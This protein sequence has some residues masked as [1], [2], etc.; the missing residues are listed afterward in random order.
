MGKITIIS[1]SGMGRSGRK[2]RGVVPSAKG[3]KLSGDAVVVKMIT[4][5]DED[6]FKSVKVPNVVSGIKRELYKGPW[7]N[8]RIESSI[9]S[10]MSWTTP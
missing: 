9:N 2:Y 4:D 5:E 3:N 8:D 7:L 1:D 10:W 6:I